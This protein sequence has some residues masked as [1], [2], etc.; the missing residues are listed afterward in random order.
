MIVQQ[1]YKFR[2][3]I[4][5]QY[6]KDHPIYKAHI[7]AVEEPVNLDGN[8]WHDNVYDGEIQKTDYDDMMDCVTNGTVN[9]AQIDIKAVWKI[10][11]D[12]SKRFLAKASDTTRN[13]NTD[14]AVVNA[15]IENGICN[16]SDWPA[17]RSMTWNDFYA[18]LT[19]LAKKLAKNF[20]LDWS[21]D[22][23]FIWMSA[24]DVAGNRIKLKAELKFGTVG[25]TGASWF[26]H[27]DGR[28]Y[29]E[30]QLANHKFVL[31]KYCNGVDPKTDGDYPVVFDSYPDDFQI[32]QDNLESPNPQ[33]Y[34]KI[35]D[36]N[37]H[38]GSAM[39]LII[40]PKSKK[41]TSLLILF[42]NMQEN[43]WSYADSKG[44]YFYFVSKLNKE[45]SIKAGLPEG[46]LCKQ[47]LDIS[48][49]P[50]EL[51]SLK[52]IFILF[53]KA[54]ITRVTSYGEVSTIKDYKFF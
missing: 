37:Y 16:E 54:K 5:K 44:V 43:L 11:L 13:G 17:D 14:E 8:L 21:I 38:F 32:D 36:K 3:L 4:P 31:L 1:N 20:L 34:I 15:L 19:I 42:K 52:A 33:E 26:K 41:K 45:Q 39:R 12:L 7:G 25:V 47:F 2:G 22:K 48:K 9:E 50:P 23:K 6:P 24:K 29:D 46:T 53:G 28:Y 49:L 30:G 27:E 40:T 10:T 51:V 18:T 35:L